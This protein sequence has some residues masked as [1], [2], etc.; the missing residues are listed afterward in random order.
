MDVRRRIIGGFV[1]GS[2]GGNIEPIDTDDYL[3]IYALEDGLTASLSTNACEYCIDGDGNWLSL[4]AGATTQSIN[5]GQR[6]SFRG[7]LTPAS[8]VGIGT[9]TISKK[10]NL[11]GNCMSML[12]GDDAANSRSLIGKN[13]AFYK[14]FYNCANI[15]SVSE[16][17]LPATILASK[18]YSYMFNSCSNLT[19]APVLPATILAN[20]CYNNMFYGCTGLIAAPELPATTLANDCYDSM[21]WNCTGLTTAPALPATTLADT[22]YAYMFDGCTSLTTAPSLPAKTLAQYC[23][24]YMFRGCSKLNYIKMLATDISATNCLYYWVSGVASTGTFVKHPNMTSLPTGTSGIPSGWTVVNEGGGSINTDNYLTIYALEDS[25]TASLTTNACEY[26]VDGDGNWKSLAAGTATESINAGHRLSFRGNLTPSDTGIGTFTISKRCNLEGNCMSMLFGDNAAN[27]LSLTGKSYAFYKLFYNCT[28]II[29]VSSNFLPATTLANNCYNSMFSGCSSLT[30]APALPA[31]TLADRCY[32]EMFYRCSNLTTAPA[33]PAT[34]LEYYCY[35]YMFQNCTSLVNAPALPATTLSFMCYEGM[36]GGCTGLTTAPALP[37]TTLANYCYRNM[38]NGCSN[39]TTAPALPATTLA[40]SC[41]YNMFNGCTSLTTAPALSATTLAPYCYSS[42]FNGCSSLTTAPALPAT[43]LTNYCYQYMFYGCSKLNYIKM[44]A[45]DISASNC[46]T[47]WVSGVASTG[48]FVKNPAMTSLPT[49]ASG[50]PSGWTVKDNYIPT[51]CTSLTITA[52]DVSGRDTTTTIYYTAVTNGKDANNNIINNVTITGTATSAPFAQNTSTTNTVQR[53]ISYT[54]LGKTATT[55]IT[56]GVWV[57]AQYTIDLNN[58]WQKSTTISNPD[59]SEYDGVYE[60]FSNY[61]INSTAA[62]MKITIDGYSSFKFYIR[63]YAE[64]SWDYVMVSQLDQTINNSTSYSNTT[65]V[66]AHTRGNQ[67]SGTALSNYTLVEFTNIDGG[68]HVITIVYRKDGS[69]NSGTDRGYV[70]LPK[71]AGDSSGSGGDSSGSGG[72][73]DINNYLTIVALED[74]LTAS[75]STNACEYCVDGDGNWLSLAADA[76]TQ[77]INTG[78]TLSFRGELTPATNVGIGTFT[79]SKKCNLE[80]NCMSMLFGD[81]A[82]DSTSLSGKKYAFCMLFN[83]CTNIVSISENFLPATTLAERCYY[84]MFYGCSKLTTAPALPATTLISICYN[85]MFMACT[86]LTSAPALPATTLAEYCYNGM[87]YGCSNLT[88]AP[89]LP[90]TTLANYCYYSMFYGCSNLTTAP[91]LPATR[92]AN[93]C[94]SSMF[95]GCSKLNYIKM[96]ATNIS[97]TSCLNYWVQNVSSTGTF[98]KDPNMTSLPTGVSGIPS[99][100]AVENSSA[101]GMSGG[102]DN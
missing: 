33:L 84:R 4:A 14:L 45:T 46:L 62:I 42:M 77:S 56:Q 59:A 61:N 98:V 11:E 102:S 89:E 9:F 81:N 92:L 16:N 51:S 72:S 24:S 97:A 41:Y 5:N 90:A 39:L 83:N 71:I 68:K 2:S 3:T 80:G 17:F 88:T 35:S 73:G 47:N 19:T 85:S 31:T 94:Y 57:A 13:Y 21:F 53:T 58:Q 70:L 67:Q 26:C 36:F 22:C 52:D 48:T 18:C 20:N 32:N 75:L 28:N 34:T 55:T 38:F 44:L 6:L 15:V 50:I 82:V 65:L 8:S 91:E 1:S 86:S 95:N 69:G 30:T 60:S 78:H 54:Y 49:G 10:C 40:E 37:A 74:G 87:F 101:G 64:S 100:W 99:G 63:S 7:E 29:R 43:T 93:Y 12:F 76:T 27:N 25:L 79:I 96:L 23:Y 66:K